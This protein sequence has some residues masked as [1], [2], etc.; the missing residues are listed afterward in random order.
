MA[1]KY[2]NPTALTGSN[3]DD[4]YLRTLL[5]K[6]GDTTDASAQIKTCK[7]YGVDATFHQN[8]TKEA[9][10][11]ELR[12]G[13]PVGTGILHHGH[14]SSPRGGGHW[15]LLIGDDGNSGVFHDPYGELD[16]VNG[17]YVR[18]GSGGKGV[19]YTWKNWLPRWEVD[20]PRTGWFMT[21]RLSH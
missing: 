16:N 17:G 13:F 3:A 4:T 8:G 7:Y 15:M 18:V 1:V 9:L 12:S 19:K 6:Y 11:A 20:G 14:V 5:N 2:L 21:F 10:L